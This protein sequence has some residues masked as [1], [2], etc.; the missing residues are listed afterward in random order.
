MQRIKLL[1]AEQC[2]PKGNYSKVNR[3]LFLVLIFGLNF[4]RDIRDGGFSIGYLRSTGFK[5][6]IISFHDIRKKKNGTE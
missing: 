2:S 3:Y 6:E 4:N 5:V 1:L